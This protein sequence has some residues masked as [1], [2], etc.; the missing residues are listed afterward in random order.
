M[1]VSTAQE[2]ESAIH[3]KESLTGEKNAVKCVLRLLLLWA[4]EAQLMQTVPLYCL[5]LKTRTWEIHL[6]TPIS[7]CWMVTLG[8]IGCGLLGGAHGWASFYGSKNPERHIEP[9]DGSLRQDL[10]MCVG[11]TYSATMTGRLRACGSGQEKKK[12]RE[13]DSS[14][15]QLPGALLF[16]G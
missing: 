7:H 2:N 4:T 15:L 12:K 6:L 5:F 13:R 9:C 1:L 14:M 10:E 11:E 3:K 8:G 16:H